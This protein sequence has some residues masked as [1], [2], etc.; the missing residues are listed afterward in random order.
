MMV[1]DYKRGGLA[2]F[3]SLDTPGGAGIG[4][5]PNY[6]S[7]NSRAEVGGDW[8]VRAIVAEVCETC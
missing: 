7:R 1:D 5:S 3:H 4:M 2:L 6:S 8:V